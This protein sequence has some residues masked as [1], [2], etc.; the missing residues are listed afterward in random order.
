MKQ[1]RIRS[2]WLEAHQTA[3]SDANG[4]DEQSK[5]CRD[6]VVAFFRQNVDDAKRF[7]ASAVEWFKSERDQPYS[8]VW[9]CLVLDMDPGQVR[10]RL[11]IHKS[12]SGAY[13]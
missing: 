11:G 3:P 1:T 4:I 6:L 9:C 2:A 10:T 8:F 7:S 5:R 13:H 12:N